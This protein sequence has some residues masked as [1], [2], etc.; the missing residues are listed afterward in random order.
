MARL[1]NGKLVD[2][3]SHR[4][5]EIIRSIPHGR[6]AVQIH[7]KTVKNLDPYKNYDPDSI[8]RIRV[9]PD[10]S[11]GGYFMPRSNAS[12]R[13][14]HE[15]IVAVSENLFKHHSDIDYDD[16]NYDWMTVERYKLPQGW[17]PKISPLMII[18][19][20]EYPQLAP[21]GFYLP[22]RARSPHGHLMSGA[23]H[24]ASDAPVHKGWNWYCTYVNSGSWCPAYGRYAD[25]WRKGDNLFDYFVLIGE[26]LASNE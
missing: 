9:M 5:E 11:K 18:F 15:Q 1:N 22:D 19:P 7:G 26:V 2:G 14:I 6:R 24:G 8:R 13:M 23:Y 21:V 4:G 25:D 10:R 12:R 16:I 3:N 17:E 20:T